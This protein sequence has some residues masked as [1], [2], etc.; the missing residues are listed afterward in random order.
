M[1]SAVY[2]RP[3]PG[4][5]VKE[6]QSHP[7]T[8]QRKFAADKLFRGFSETPETRSYT[9][10]SQ[11]T[12]RYN[13]QRSSPANFEQGKDR[14]PKTHATTV[15]PLDTGL[16]TVQKK[17]TSLTTPAVPNEVLSLIDFNLCLDRYE[18]E[19]ESVQVYNVK[20]RLYNSLQFW[21]EK[22]LLA[23]S[24]KNLVLPILESGYVRN[25]PIHLLLYF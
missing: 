1:M 24:L 5:F 20:G 15:M 13:G 2:D 3:K 12:P 17:P 16:L 18:Y 4:Q 21:K 25:L 8:H 11:T 6:R 22:L 14:L 23:D 19:N 7:K 9:N 10:G